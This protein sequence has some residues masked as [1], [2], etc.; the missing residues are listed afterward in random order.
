MKIYPRLKL[1][2]NLLHLVLALLEIKQVAGIKEIEIC[3]NPINP[4]VKN[5]YS[6]FGFVEV[7][8]DEDDEDMLAVI[9]L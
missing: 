2:D 8:M 3:Y 4:V 6:S 7:G 1:I 9:K 5:F